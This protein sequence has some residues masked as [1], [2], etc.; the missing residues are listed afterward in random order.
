M[1]FRSRALLGTTGELLEFTGGE[2]WATLG[3]EHWKV[4]GAPD[5]RSGQTV[6]VLGADGVVLQVAASA[7]PFAEQPTGVPP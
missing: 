2:G 1:L 5:L 3:G 7:A 4:R 6:R